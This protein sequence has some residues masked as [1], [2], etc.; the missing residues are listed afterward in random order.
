MRFLSLLTGLYLLGFGTVQ[1]QWQLQTSST[2]A[3]FRT[4]SAVSKDVV[5]VSGSKGTVLRTI[6]GGGH[7]Q[8]DTVP[9]AGTCDFRGI[10]GFSA[11]EA[12]VMSAGPADK[13]YARLYQTYDG[14]KSWQLAY[15]ITTPGV[16]F[17]GIAFWDRQHGIVFS[18]PVDNKWFILRTDDGGKTWSPLPS[19]K[20]PALQPGEAAFAAS[21]S[22]ITLQG[23]KNVWIGSGGSSFGRV[24][25][26]A[27]RG[28]T[29]SVAATP[30]A[31]NSTSGVFGLSFRDATH[32]IAVGGNYKQEDEP[33]PNI[34]TTADGGQTWQPV[35]P[36]LPAGLKEAVVS[37]P[38]Q[39]L[40]TVGPSGT[41]VSAD[42]GQTWQNGETEGFHAVSCS[43]RTCWTVGPKG[44]IARQTF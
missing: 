17:D 33:V 4:V 31:G 30:L 9:G 42:N 24:F 11:T 10:V 13:G 23:N 19:D 20:L 35:T 15:Q 21:N 3:S 2:T 38:Q 40:L 32:G 18:D 43:G 16:F 29:W 12:I 26:S 6:D 25:H 34:V 1:A 22:S 39:R 28:N 8:T 44:K 41:S 36:A 27:D 5:W 14:G 37:L 7:W